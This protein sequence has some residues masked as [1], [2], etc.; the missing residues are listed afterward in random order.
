MSQPEKK[1]LKLRL[2]PLI[3]QLKIRR[4]VLQLVKM[5]SIIPTALSGHLYQHLNIC[6]LPLQFSPQAATS[7][8]HALYLRWQHLRGDSHN[9]EHTCLDIPVRPKIR[10]NQPKYANVDFNVHQKSNRW[11]IQLIRFAQTVNKKVFPKHSEHP[12][13]W[14][15]SQMKNHR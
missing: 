8:H 15:F 9:S 5:I 6:R 7:H 3:Y 4:L 11:S 10:I 1:L 14:V 13:G 2:Q 12:T